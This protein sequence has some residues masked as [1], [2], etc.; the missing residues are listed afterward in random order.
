[1]KK[2]GF[3]ATRSMLDRITPQIVEQFAKAN[4]ENA[5]E[6]VDLAKVLIPERSGENRS[7]IRN[8]AM[9]GGAQLVDFGPKAKVIEGESGPTPFKNRSMKATKKRR[10][11]RNRKAI[12]DAIKA[13]KN[14]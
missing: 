10:S 7:A 5:E 1:V 13:V 14:G 4:R 6:I 3:D 11:A 2:T 12:R 9:E 8:T